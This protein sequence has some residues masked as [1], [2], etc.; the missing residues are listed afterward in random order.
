MSELCGSVPSPSHVSESTDL[1]VPVVVRSEIGVQFGWVRRVGRRGAT[2]ELEE[3]PPLRSSLEV[4]FELL[5][6]DTIHS[7]SL[8][9]RVKHI[10][11]WAAGDDGRRHRQIKVQWSSPALVPA[12]RH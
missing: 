1:A 7:M 2:I 3:L 4:T 9:G 12:V 11:L 8:I 6:A 10:M 5:E